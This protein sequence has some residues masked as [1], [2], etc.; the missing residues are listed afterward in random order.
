MTHSV[1][2]EVLITEYLVRQVATTAKLSLTAQEVE[3]FQRE[4]AEIIAAFSVLDR[5]DVEGITPSFLPIPRK[6]HL[7]EDVVR[8]SLS[9]EEALRFTKQQENGFFLGPKTIE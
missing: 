1:P 2:K 9:Q 6:N 8:A 4:L 5:I 3:Q 7:R